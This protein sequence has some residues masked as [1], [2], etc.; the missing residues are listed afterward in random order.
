MG[1][2]NASLPEALGGSP[3][4]A[5]GYF[6]RALEATERHNFAVQMS[7]ART[8]AVQVQDRNLYVSLLREIVDGGDPVAQNRLLN[9]MMRRRA[10]RWLNRTDQLFSE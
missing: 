2:L 7:Y 5:R 4:E 9:R 1:V 3:D 10:I 8:Y 6:E